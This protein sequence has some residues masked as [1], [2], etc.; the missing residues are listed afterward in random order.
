MREIGRRAAAVTDRTEGEEEDLPCLPEQSLVQAFPER[1]VQ[2]EDPQGGSVAA[3]GG[4]ENCD[5][6]TARMC[7][8]MSYHVTPP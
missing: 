3:A 8:V 7:M 1:V 2:T 5:V 6:R 4:A